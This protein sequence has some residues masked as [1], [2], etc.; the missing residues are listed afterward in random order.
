MKYAVVKDAVGNIQEIAIFCNNQNLPNEYTECTFSEY[1]TFRT[2]I[3]SLDAIKAHCCDHID[4]KAGDVRLK[5]ITDVPGQQATYQMKADECKE[6]K[7]L[8][9]PDDSDMTNYPLIKAEMAV[10]GLTCNQ[11][12]DM[13]IAIESGWKFLAASIEQA[14][15][16]G[17]QSIMGATDIN[18]VLT[19]EQ[20]ALQTLNTL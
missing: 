3:N 10:T 12:A 4:K 9:L 18:G 5:Y 6:I 14:R 2:S 1:E 17:K 11:V 16:M 20:Y 8:G 13:I 19:Q 7:R 15:R